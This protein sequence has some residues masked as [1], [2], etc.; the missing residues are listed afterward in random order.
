MTARQDDGSEVVI[1][2]QEEGSFLGQARLDP[3]AGARIR[4][5]AIGEVTM[6]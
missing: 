6:V 2:S 1:W 4:P 5:Y 3:A